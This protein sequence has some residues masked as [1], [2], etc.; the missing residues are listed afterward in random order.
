MDN[1]GYAGTT[2]LRNCGNWLRFATPRQLVNE[3]TS[4]AA[5]T[6]S[7]VDSLS[8]CLVVCEALAEPKN[9]TLLHYKRSEGKESKE[10]KESKEGFSTFC[11]FK[12]QQTTDNGQRTTDNG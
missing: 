9:I 8:R 6:C 4:G 1:R 12:G 2:E 11:T 5:A 7:L 10:S 3:T